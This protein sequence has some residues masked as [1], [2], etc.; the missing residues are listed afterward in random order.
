MRVRNKCTKCKHKWKDEPG[1]QLST[2]KVCPSCGSAYWKWSSFP[3]DKKKYGGK[4]D[5]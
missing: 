4:D 2:H 1:A 5:F 3:L